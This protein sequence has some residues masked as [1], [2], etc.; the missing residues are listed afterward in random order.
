MRGRYPVVFGRH[1]MSFWTDYAMHVAVA[2]AFYA[3]Y[4][5]LLYWFHR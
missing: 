3:V 1:L 5:L 2:V 4:G